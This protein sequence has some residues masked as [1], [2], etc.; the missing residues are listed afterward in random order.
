MESHP[1]HRKRNKGQDFYEPIDE[2]QAEGSLYDMKR[3]F[4]LVTLG[5]VVF[6][7]TSCQK[8]QDKTLE[9]NLF[10]FIVSCTGGSL[11]ACNADCAAKYPNITGDNYPTASTCFSN[12]STNC[13]LSATLLLLTN[14]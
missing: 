2:M 8:R 13:S 7:S 3:F 10:T 11:T 12:C 5:F 9:R 1:K 4:L 14:K 6:F